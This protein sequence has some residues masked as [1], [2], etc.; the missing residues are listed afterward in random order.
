MEQHF[1]FPAYRADLRYRLYSAHLVVRNHDAYQ[2]SVVSDRVFYF[3]Y[4][5]YAV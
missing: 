3:L 1:L 4:I 2:S 5:D